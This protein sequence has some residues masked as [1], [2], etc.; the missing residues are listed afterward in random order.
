MPVAY[1]KLYNIV[2]VDVLSVL[3]LRILDF[4]VSSS[5]LFVRK[6]SIT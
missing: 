3:S 1:I 6:S 2:P 4:H 5:G